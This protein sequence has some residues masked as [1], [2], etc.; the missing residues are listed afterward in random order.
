MAIGDF[1]AQAEAYVR[2]RPGYPTALIDRIVRHIDLPDGAAVADIGAGTG[3]FTR[4]LV[5][6]GYV[7]TGIEPND[8]MRAL[9]DVRLVDGSFEATGLPSGSQA[10]VMAAQAFHWADPSRALPEIARVLVDKGAFSVMWNNRLN[11]ADPV[12]KWTRAA[13]A[14]IVPDFDH[15]YRDTDWA[16]V[17]TGGAHFGDVRYDEEAHVV[18]MSRSRYLDL[19]RGH[20]RL[21]SI[22]GPDRFATF[23]DELCNHL[24]EGAVERVDVPYLVKSWT[25]IKSQ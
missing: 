7:V 9:S 23:M 12:V 10:W 15:A 17:L 11:D 13:I 22:A 1:S 2:S 20:N 3:I 5:A 19:W 16:A 25:A 4:D 8:K 24:D 21:N 14:R 6:R 18:A